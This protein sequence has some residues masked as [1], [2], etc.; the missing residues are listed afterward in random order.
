MTENSPTFAGPR[1]SAHFRRSVVLGGLGAA[2]RLFA[3]LLRADG[4]VT[5]VDRRSGETPPG[6]SLL[7]A[8]AC[9]PDAPLRA[10]LNRADAVLVALPESAGIAAVEAIAAHLPPGALLAETS[11]V[12]SAIAEALSRLAGRHDLEAAGVNPMF[13]PGLGFPGRPVLFARI[14]DGQRCRRL[15]TLIEHSGARLVPVSVEG[16]DRLTAALQVAT[17][18]S[19]LAFGNALRL[20]GEDAA[21]LTA[22][23]PPPHRTML[24]LLARI[25][26]GTPEVYRDIQM[27]HPHASDA[28]AALA[29]SLAQLDA[30][31]TG[32]PDRFD[33]LLED[34]SA[35][36]GP[37]RDQLAADCADLFA[38]L[39]SR[40]PFDCTP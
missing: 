16:H 39:A 20:L 31:S 29:K 6:M 3:E 21:E 9:Q 7:V 2:G 15:E 32:P 10:E 26:T 13:A 18:A 27:A 28:R 30:V 17:H 12:K 35:W 37:A 14:R 4:A 25:V 8:D 19:V 40:R 33:A 36:L 38:R 34:L 1:P 23:A 11:S 5:L 24:A 22:A